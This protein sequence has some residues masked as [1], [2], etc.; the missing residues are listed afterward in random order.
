MTTTITKRFLPRRRI[1]TRN[2]G[3]TM[4]IGDRIRLSTPDNERLHGT[5][6][7]IVELTDWGAHCEAPA[8]ATG[9]FRALWSEMETS[10]AYV[11]E[12]C[13]CC[14]GPNLRWAGACK[15]CE[16]CGNTGGCG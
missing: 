12:C 1:Q 6:A 15:V 16:D 10:I 7:T 14:G 4:L 8:A 2:G 5:N 9:A 3:P 13:T 11:G